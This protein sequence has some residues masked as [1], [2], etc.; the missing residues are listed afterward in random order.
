M[1]GRKLVTRQGDREFQALSEHIIAF[2]K[3]SSILIKILKTS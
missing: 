2:L 1:N 3:G